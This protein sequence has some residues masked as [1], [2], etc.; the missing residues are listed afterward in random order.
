MRFALSTRRRFS[1]GEKRCMSYGPLGITI[2][3]MDM[4]WVCDDWC[5]FLL[6]TYM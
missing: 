6:Y 2:W 5:G 4:G 3:V 1:P